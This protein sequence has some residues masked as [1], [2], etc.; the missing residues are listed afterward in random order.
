ML[1]LTLALSAAGAAR[2]APPQPEAPSGGTELLP[3][4]DFASAASGGGGLPA[5]WDVVCANNATC[6]SF[7]HTTR[8][9]DTVLLASG[10]GRAETYGWAET[11]VTAPLRVGQSYCLTAE[12]G[13]EGL[14]DL[15]RHTRIELNGPGYLSGLFE[16]DRPCAGALSAQAA[17]SCRSGAG[18]WV[19]GQKRFTYG[20]PSPMSSSNGTGTVRLYLKYTPH[21]RVWW[22]KVSLTECEPAPKRPP[23]RPRVHPTP[24]AAPQTPADSGR[25]GRGRSRRRGGR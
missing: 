4:G 18:S 16:Y 17:A 10:S 23:V 12:L 8:A 20:W 21:G 2:A 3:Q 1:R 11:N 13:Y 9:G 19:T 15:Q 5:H 22:R 24:T 25:C 7:A 6:P 14:V